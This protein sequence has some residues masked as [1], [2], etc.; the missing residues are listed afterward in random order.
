MEPKNPPGSTAIPAQRLDGTPPVGETGAAGESEL[1]SLFSEYAGEAPAAASP[2]TRL[3]DVIE[4]KVRGA[5]TY[6][7]QHR[8]VTIAVGF[9]L[10]FTLGRMLRRRS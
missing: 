2:I 9:G 3:R 6:L 4:P 10:G 1:D 5:I 7:E 8:L